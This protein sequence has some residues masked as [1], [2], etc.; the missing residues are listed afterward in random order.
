MSEQAYRAGAF[1]PAARR[2]PGQNNG[3]AAP[4]AVVGLCIAALALVW[5]LVNHVHSVEWRDAVILHDFTGLR[6]SP[7]D[8]VAS[9]TLH[10]VDPVEFILWGVSLV[11][12]ALA[13]GRPRVAVAVVA[14]MALAPFTSE[15]LKPILAH[16]HLQIGAV[17][18]G[19]ASWPSGHATAAAALAM[20]AVL[21]APPHL[22]RLVA[23]IGAVFCLVVGCF[24][25]I[26]A[27]HMPSDVIGGF[28]VATCWTAFAVAVLRASEQA[29]PTRSPP[30]H[31]AG[32]LPG[33]T[34]APPVRPGGARPPGWPP[35]R[36]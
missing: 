25:L 8:S 10:L 3:L 20:C 30:R 23:T 11:A 2:G 5:A 7:L 14:V 12:L 4:L 32:G 17:M 16:P 27:W 34:A 6:G 24:L 26:L 21:V 1:H 36:G 18:V 31:P 35:S 13:R 28:L 15:R 9:D 33:P 29:W 19:P 22:R